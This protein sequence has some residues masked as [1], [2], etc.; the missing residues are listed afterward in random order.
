MPRHTLTLTD[1]QKTALTKMRNN[2]QPAYLRERAAA[3]LKIG[4][5]MSPHKVAL[6]GLLKKRKPDTVYDWLSRFRKQGIQGLFQKSGRGRKPAFAPKSEEEAEA[7][8]QNIVSMSPDTI[9]GHATRWTLRQIKGAVPWLANIKV[10]IT[11]F[12]TSVLVTSVV[13]PHP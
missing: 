7:E 8:I 4:S 6:S 10:C 12:Q 13:E 5:G 3:I 2:G 1:E 11:F 9:S